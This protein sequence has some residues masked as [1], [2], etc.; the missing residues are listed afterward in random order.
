MQVH[1][2]REVAMMRTLAD[3]R[4]NLC[5]SCGFLIAVSLELCT[6]ASRRD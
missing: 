2:R 5:A 4:Q 3:D 6:E 1:A